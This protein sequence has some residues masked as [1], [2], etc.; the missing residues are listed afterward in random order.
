MSPEVRTNFFEG[1]VPQSPFTKIRN[2]CSKFIK[3]Y[4]FQVHIRRKSTKQD[5]KG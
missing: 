1:N 2:I 4:Y 5:R 3:T